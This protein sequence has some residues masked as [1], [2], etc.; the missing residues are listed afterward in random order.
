MTVNYHRLACCPLSS[1]IFAACTG[2]YTPL[3]KML[4]CYI[5]VTIDYRQNL[6]NDKRSKGG[7]HLEFEELSYMREIYAPKKLGD[8]CT[9][10]I[11]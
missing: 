6:M 4:A 1:P 9:V 10:S 2:V 8:I 11:R 7:A 3:Q 5:F